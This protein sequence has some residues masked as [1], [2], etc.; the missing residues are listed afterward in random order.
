M[1]EALVEAKSQLEKEEEEL[2]KTISGIATQSKEIEDK[3]L[4]FEEFDLEMERKRQLFQQLQDRLFV[5][6]LT[7]LFHKTGAQ[8]SGENTGEVIKIE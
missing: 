8:K 3:I 6:Q 2:E 1:E 5:D 4:Q 7:V